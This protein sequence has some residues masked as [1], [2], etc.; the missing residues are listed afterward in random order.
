VITSAVAANAKP[1]ATMTLLQAAFSHNSFSPDFDSTHK[2][3]SFRSVISGKKCA[4]PILITHTVRDLA[5]GIAYAVASR[6][7]GQNDSAIGDE[8]DIYGGLGRNGAR[9]T[10]EAS[11]SDLL[12]EGS[13][14]SLTAGRIANL[15]ADN[16]IQGHGDIVKPETAWALAVAAGLGAA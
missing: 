4:G 14:Y 10:P 1:V 9:H 7:A 13:P 6:L 11:D 12:S 5:V 15:R 3:G 16:I 2:P 8:N